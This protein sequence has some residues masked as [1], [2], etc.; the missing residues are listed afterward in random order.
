MVRQ[1]LLK[2][3]LIAIK[4]TIRSRDEEAEAKPKPC[5]FEALIRIR[6]GDTEYAR[7]LNSFV[8]QRFWQMT[9]QG[10]AHSMSAVGM[11]APFIESL[12]VAIFDGTAKTRGEYTG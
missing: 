9:F 1:T 7:H 10:S 12:F 5:Q 11:L 3:Q 2:T 4:R 8:D 6:A